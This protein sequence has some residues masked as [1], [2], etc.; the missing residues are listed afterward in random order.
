[1]SIW[2][3]STG[4]TIHTRRWQRFQDRKKHEPSPDSRRLKHKWGSR[5]TR[6]IVQGVS[7][8]PL[9]PAPRGTPTGTPYLGCKI[10]VPTPPW[11]RLNNGRRYLTSPWHRRVR[12]TFPLQMKAMPEVISLDENPA[13]TLQKLNIWNCLTYSS[14]YRK[15]STGMSAL[16]IMAPIDCLINYPNTD[17]AV[18]QAN[19]TFFF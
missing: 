9:K 19:T 10:R 14:C 12:H 1:M 3:R 6:S 5:T 2:S 4:K 15:N 16:L 13:A 18:Y 7:G 8:M 11:Y 17:N